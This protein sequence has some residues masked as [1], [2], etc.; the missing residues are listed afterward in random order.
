[1]KKLFILLLCLFASAA[2]AQVALPSV[3]KSGS[4]TTGGTFQT[5]TLPT[6]VR[7]SLE[8]MNI[9]NIAGNCTATTDECY[10]HFGSDSATVANSIPVD[11]DREY[12]R[13]TGVIQNDT[14]QVTCTTT[15]DKFYLK[16][17]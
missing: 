3:D 14:L 17:Q 1:M 12:L 7:N 4:V 2:V 8:F 16:L 11:P 10:I 5:I 13:S 6:G 15:A 9:C